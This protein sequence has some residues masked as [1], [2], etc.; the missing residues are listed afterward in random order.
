MYKCEER[1]VTFQNDSAAGNEKVLLYFQPFFFSPGW[2]KMDCCWR[3]TEEM[4]QIMKGP[5]EI[6]LLATD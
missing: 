6:L 2:R 3:R 1:S 5:L 4:L